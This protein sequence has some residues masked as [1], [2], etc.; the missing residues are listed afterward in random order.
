MKYYIWLLLFALVFCCRKPVRTDPTSRLEKA[1]AAF[2]RKNVGR[3]SATIRFQVLD[4]AYYA[5][6]DFYECEFHVRMTSPSGD[7]TGMMKAR[8]SSDYSKVTRKW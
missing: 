8:I 1:M 4:V 5:D 2:L 3:D 6:K 7:T